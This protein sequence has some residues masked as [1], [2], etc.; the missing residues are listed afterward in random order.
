MTQHRELRES[1]RLARDSPMWD[2]LTMPRAQSY[3]KKSFY[4][5]TLLFKL[6]TFDPQPN[7]VIGAMTSFMLVPIYM[8]TREV[9]KIIC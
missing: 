9:R 8:L 6:N 4:N 5:S 3:E 7:R 1:F 2:S